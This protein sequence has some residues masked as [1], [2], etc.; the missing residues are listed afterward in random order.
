MELS[1]R[2]SALFALPYDDVTKGKV[3]QFEKDFEALP[4]AKFGLARTILPA[5]SLVTKVGEAVTGL[6]STF[7]EVA[8][9]IYRSKHGRDPVSVAD[10]KEIL[11]A[12]AA[13]VAAE[14]AEAGA[15]Q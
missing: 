13:F 11:D 14:A 5:A 4:A 6:D 9:A 15:G 3:A 2:Q 8:T 1:E 12:A 7:T 10:F